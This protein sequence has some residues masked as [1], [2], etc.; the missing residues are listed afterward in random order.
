MAD[1]HFPTLVSKDRDANLVANPMWVE[2]SDGAAVLHKVTDSAAGGT[3]TGIAPLAVRDDALTTLTPA[4]GDYTPLR[5]GSTGALWVTMTNASG[6]TQY[7]EDAAHT[8]GDMGTMAL[9]V[10]KDSIASNAGADGDYASLLTDA[11]GRLYVNIFDGGNTITVDGS[12][13]I[14]GSVTVTATAL[15]IRTITKATDSIQVSSNTVAN[16]P[17]NP[18][19]VQT[20]DV[21]ILSNEV[22]SYDT[23]ASVTAD[24]ADNHDYTVSGTTFLLKEVIVSSSGGSKV[25]VQTGP[26][27]TLVT[28]MVGFIPKEGGTLVIPFNPPREV[29][30]TSTGTVRVIRTNRQGASQDLYSTIMGN[31]VA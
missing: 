25:E 5:V 3:D 13:S 11:T 22:H 24:T 6:G 4:D 12:V 10:R 18:I 31:D 16:G 27:G 29:P 21:G 15:D 9:A 1:G 8:D 23:T 26:V 20:V 14:T 19:Y 17:T 2:L 28:I 7:A 30:V